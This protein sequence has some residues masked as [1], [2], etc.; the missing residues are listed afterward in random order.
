MKSQRPREVR[1]KSGRSTL[2]G[3]LRLPRDAR[4]VV[5]F[6][7]GTGSGRLSPRNNLVA[8]ALARRGLASLLCDLLT[9]Q[10]EGEDRWGSHWRFDIGFL[11]RRL[12]RASDW[13]LDESHLGFRRLSYFGAST[14]AAA[15]IVEAGRL[16]GRVSALVCRG[17]RPDLAGSSLTLVRCPTLLIVGGDDPE[18]IELNQQA[19]G[20]LSCEKKL[21]IV[22]GATHLFEEPGAL[23]R[24]AELAGDWLERHSRAPAR[25]RQAADF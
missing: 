24:V 11:A 3:L 23:E 14:G 7:H 9:G 18:V 16:P 19:L 13:L 22:P 1:I 8:E 17:G 5:L 20:R 25:S 12:E 6:A 10:E 15:A 2:E 21:V 4:G